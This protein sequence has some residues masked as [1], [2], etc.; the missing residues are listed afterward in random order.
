MR[1]D[2]EIFDFGSVG[3]DGVEW[4]WEREDMGMGVI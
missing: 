3:V 1:S 4:S 2:F